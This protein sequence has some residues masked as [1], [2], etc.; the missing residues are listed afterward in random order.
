[1]FLLNKHIKHSFVHIFESALEVQQTDTKL[2]KIKGSYLYK[3]TVLQYL[4]VFSAEFG[5]RQ[6]LY[7][8]NSLG[9][10]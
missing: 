1:M 6:R 4:V 9:D 5:L 10:F 8:Q 2:L 7:L 3:I